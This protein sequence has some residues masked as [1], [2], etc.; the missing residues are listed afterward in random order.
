MNNPVVNKNKQIALMAALWLSNQASLAQSS[1]VGPAATTS[2]P[3]FNGVKW[4]KATKAGSNAFINSDFG[5]AERNFK[6]ALEEVKLAPANDIR[7]AE[8]FNNLGVL[9]VSRGLPAKAEPYFEKAA[10]IREAA[11]GSSDKDVIAGQ[12]KLAQFYLSVGKR[13][14]ALVIINKIADY[15]DYESKQLNEISAAFKKLSLYYHNHRKLEDSEIAVKQAEEK[16]LSEMKAQA[17]ETAVMLDAVGNSVKDN[18]KLAERLF[19]AALTLRERTLS[20]EHAAL[21]SSLENLGKLYMSDGRT[22]QAEPLLRRAYEI[23]LNTLGPDRQ[24]TQKRL[25][26]LAQ[27]C[28]LLNKNSEAENL[29][30]K[31]LDSQE[32]GAKKNSPELLANFASLLVKQ[33]RA[34]EALP[35]YARAL[36]IQESLNGPQHASLATL[37][38]SYAYALN[39]CNRTA[40]AQ[41]CQAR[42]KFIRG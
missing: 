19:K 10:K 25:D 18:N 11:L 36:K 32:K 22:A 42:A 3:S 2:P 20:G 4:A 27:V 14:K 1:Q 12:S 8:S 28:T 34:G 41:K 40:E 21:A 9:Y 6:E 35:Y 26:N 33:G 16:T 15:G 30:R 39:K 7:I 17:V 38:D 31:I 5:A 37:L 13:D 29:Y 23:S 24:E